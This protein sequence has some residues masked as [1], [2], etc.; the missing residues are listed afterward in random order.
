MDGVSLESLQPRID[1]P[2]SEVECK[3]TEEI[4]GLGN[5]VKLDV[6]IRHDWSDHQ[7]FPSTRRPM[8][9]ACTSEGLDFG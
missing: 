8:V 4:A 6:A 2:V 9:H 1:F 3:P 5:S 7:A